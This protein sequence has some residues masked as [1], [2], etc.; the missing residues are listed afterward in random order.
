MT[1]WIHCVRCGG[2]V[3]EFEED[4]SQCGLQNIWSYH[5]A[6][7]NDVVIDFMTTGTDPRMAPRSDS[8]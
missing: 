7:I 1:M 2:V 8:G 3:D 5:H 6:L 4:C